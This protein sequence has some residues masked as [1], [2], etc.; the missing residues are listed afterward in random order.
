M[1]SNLK[2]LGNVEQFTIQRL[3]NRNDDLL[4]MGFS[5]DDLIFLEGV[6]KHLL[7]LTFV[8][9]TTPSIELGAFQCRME[10]AIQQFYTHFDK[11][12]DSEEVL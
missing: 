4:F 7:D 9:G 10:E 5:E 2:Q 11:E 1:E 12:E 3:E 8:T 6:A